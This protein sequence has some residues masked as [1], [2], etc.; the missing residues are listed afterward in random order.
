VRP[1]S[2]FKRTNWRI[3]FKTSEVNFLAHTLETVYPSAPDL[4]IRRQLHW[5][6][7]KVLP[8]SLKQQHKYL[9]RR[10][11]VKGLWALEAAAYRNC[12]SDLQNAIPKWE[13]SLVREFDWAVWVVD[14]RSLGWGEVGD[15]LPGATS[16][17]MRLAPVGA[18]NVARFLEKSWGFIYELINVRVFFCLT[19]TLKLCS[20]ANVN[21]GEAR[22]V[23][24]RIL[25]TVL[26]LIYWSQVTTGSKTQVLKTRN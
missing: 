19:V 4:V 18:S 9:E 10:S 22:W 3:C 14:L 11:E 23:E 13:Q 24:G 25:D 1:P 17:H 20:S 16:K 26:Q 6:S 12:H 5:V 8:H 7:F 2:H 15:C 21:R